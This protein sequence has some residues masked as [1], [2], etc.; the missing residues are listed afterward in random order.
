M[1]GIL[2]GFVFLALLFTG[3]CCGFCCNCC[4]RGPIFAYFGKAKKALRRRKSPAIK[5]S[6]KADAASSA[7]ELSHTKDVDGSS[8]VADSAGLPAATPADDKAARRLLAL[9]G[10]PE[11]S[12][13]DGPEPIIDFVENKAHCG[14]LTP[15][16]F[17]YTF[18]LGSCIVMSGSALIGPENTLPLSPH[19]SGAT[20]IRALCRSP[21][22]GTVQ[23]VFAPTVGSKNAFVGGHIAWSTMLE[24]PTDLCEDKIVRSN[25]GT[26]ALSL[27]LSR[28]R[29]CLSPCRA[30]PAMP[31][32]S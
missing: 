28:A 7:K 31:R 32:T 18:A 14:C 29:A 26:L 25:E 19:W 23:D 2:A 10:P 4:C 20:A 3:C 27:S 24:M 30:P 6:K 16:L 21:I 11:K 13:K 1:Y 12:S 22:T 8:E 15:C 9:S 17:V 5:D